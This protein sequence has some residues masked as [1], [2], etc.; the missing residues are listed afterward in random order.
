MFLYELLGQTRDKIKIRSELLNILLAGRDTT[1]SLLSNIWFELS[2]RQDV[3]R[4]L[5]K[6]VDSLEGEIPSFEQLR[7]MKYLRAVVNESLRLYPIVP[8]NTREALK[9]A[10]LPFGGGQDGTGRLFVP[11]GQFLT[12]ST[13]SMHRRK[14]VF[15]EDANDFR[16][17]R[18]VDTEEEKGI[19]PGWA[20]LPFNGG[21]R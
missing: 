18:W 4:R 12:W 14:D 21:P 1:A 8:L 13:Y 17:D 6:E 2:K 9:D 5:R 7:K 3:W 20:F 16:P 15:G 19:R 11:K 10:V